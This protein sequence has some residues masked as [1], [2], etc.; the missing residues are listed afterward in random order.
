MSV[1]RGMAMTIAVSMAASAAASAAQEE[2]SPTVTEVTSVPVGGFAQTCQHSGGACNCQPA[3]PAITGTT[4]A[5][6][7]APKGWQQQQVV[8]FYAASD[9]ASKLANVKQIMTDNVTPPKVAMKQAGFEWTDIE[10]FSD[11]QSEW[12][13]QVRCCS[14]LCTGALSLDSTPSCHVP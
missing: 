12:I 6:S 5:G 14:V 3:A 4:P 1:H 2:A 9:T 8:D 7:A 10:I 13:D 11:K